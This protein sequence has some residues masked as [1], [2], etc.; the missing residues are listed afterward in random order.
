MVCYLHSHETW[1]NQSENNLTLQVKNTFQNP[2]FAIHSNKIKNEKDHR[3]GSI[4]YI[5]LY[6]L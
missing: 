6:S 1:Y 5:K 4:Y 3:A 2:I